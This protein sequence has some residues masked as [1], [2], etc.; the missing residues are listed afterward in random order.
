M[1]GVT[2]CRRGLACT[3]DISTRFPKDD[4]EF[5]GIELICTGTI[6]NSADKCDVHYRLAGNSKQ[7]NALPAQDQRA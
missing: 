6:A 7:H 1:I 4:F 5:K 2:A 3:A